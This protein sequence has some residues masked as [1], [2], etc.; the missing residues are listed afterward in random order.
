MVAIYARQSVDKKDSIS[1]ETQIELCQRELA[2][3]QKYRLY[4]D[5]GYSGSNLKRPDFQLM[6]EHVRSGI[7]K[8]IITYRLDRIS[9]SVLDFANLINLFDQFGVTFNSTQEKFDTGAPIGKA[10]LNITMVF[11]QLERETIQQRIKDNYYSRGEKGMYLGGPAPFGFTKVDICTE[12]G[13]I[14][15]LNENTE[16]S[17]ILEEIFCM[18]GNELRTLGEIARH[19]NSRKVLSPNGKMWDASKISRTLRNAAYVKANSDV[20]VYYRKR[21]CNFTNDI[22]DF[23]MDKGCYLYGKRESNERKYTDVKDHIIS[24][25]PHEGLIDADLFLRCQNRLDKNKQI[26]N[27]RRSKKTWLTGL[28]KCKCCGYSVIPKSSNGGRYTYLYCTGKQLMNT[29]DTKGNL[30][31]LM[32][33]EKMIEE[34]VFK[35]A[36]SYSDLRAMVEATNSKARNRIQCKLLEINQNV[37]KLIE[38]AID[39]AG[40]TVEYLNNKIAELEAERQSFKKELNSLSEA[41]QDTLKKE[42]ADIKDT[43]PDL[44]TTE[45]NAIAA[46]IIN[47]INLSQNQ[48]EIEWKFDFD[49]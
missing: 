12:Q 4:Q 3:E 42:I 1:I 2:S 39:S 18:Y 29:C 24:L 27:S 33:V 23:A 40:I 6:L 25:A 37:E 14:K 38:L 16:K 11:A 48:I 13:K 15:M 19:L 47:S 44:S 45:K 9:R 36:E 7:V 21:G 35:W 22:S 10:M 41:T 30:G 17:P 20:Y 26:D 43:W 5:R 28:I 31:T 49:F 32:S 46:I 34:R 8:R